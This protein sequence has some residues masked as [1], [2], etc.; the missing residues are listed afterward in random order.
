MLL[1]LLFMITELLS[2]ARDKIINQFINEKCK[3]Y[4]ILNWCGISLSTW[5]KKNVCNIL[6]FSVLYLIK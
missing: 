3:N 2:L 6:Y 5:F 1:L 4:N